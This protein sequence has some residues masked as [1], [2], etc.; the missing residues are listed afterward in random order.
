MYDGYA[1][2]ASAFARSQVQRE[3]ARHPHNYFSSM[4]L[5]RRSD[6]GPCGHRCS[7]CRRYQRIDNTLLLSRSAYG[8]AS[9]SMR[10]GRPA[11]NAAWLLS[12]SRL[13]TMLVMTATAAVNSHAWHFSG[14]L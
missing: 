1:T 12:R 5:G 14:N 10:L 6:N 8:P 2:R 7:T 13:T 9:C 11:A 4:S 3:F